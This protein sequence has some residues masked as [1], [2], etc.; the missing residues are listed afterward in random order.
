MKVKRSRTKKFRLTD[1]KKEVCGITLYQ[2]ESLIDFGDIHAGDKG[3]WVEKEENLSQCGD[4]WVFGNAKVY[5]NAWVLDNAEVFGNAWV[6]G[7]A[8][9][10]GN[11]EVYGNANMHDAADILWISRVGSRLG[12]TT[13]FKNKDGGISIA[14]GCFY[15]TLAEFAE[16]VKETHHNNKFAKEYNLLIELIKE[17][18]EVEE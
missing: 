7:D 11:A 10:F 17:H 3:G 4:A 2:I 18:F 9:V 1:N 6:S 16:K 8:K 14:C 12:T 5:G 13:A 15:G